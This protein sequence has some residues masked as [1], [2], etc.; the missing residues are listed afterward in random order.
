MTMETSQSNDQKISFDKYEEMINTMS[1]INYIIDRNY[2]IALYSKKKWDLFASNNDGSELTEINRV[3]EKSILDRFAGNK[4]KS[5]YRSLYD[6]IFSGHKKEIVIK[7][8]C[9]SPAALRDNVLY[10]TPIYENMNTKD[11]VIGVL[12]QS[13]IL[14]VEEREAVDLIKRKNVDSETE[15]LEMCTICKAVKYQSN[16]S[17][18]WITDEEY[19]NLGGNS[20]I[21]L[22]YSLC[23]DCTTTLDEFL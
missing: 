2:S 14:N 12:H 21:K 15:F 3:K 20:S 7:S 1:G 11:N 10:L 13:L 9:D 23:I 22:E 19:Q 6:Q 16:G 17:D 4:V 18:K 8:K 5:Y